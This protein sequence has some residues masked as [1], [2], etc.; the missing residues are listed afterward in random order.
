MVLS[1]AP[2]TNSLE[3]LP[4]KVKSTNSDSELALILA[5][6]EVSNKAS[7]ACSSLTSANLALMIFVKFSTY[8][9]FC[10][11]ETETKLTLT[12]NFFPSTVDETIPFLIPAFLTKTLAELMMPSTT[13][14][15]SNSYS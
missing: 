8:K 3:S 12:V 9:S 10:A 5:L 4:T 11:G 13:S 2:L 1:I 14:F 15:S 6:K 7:E